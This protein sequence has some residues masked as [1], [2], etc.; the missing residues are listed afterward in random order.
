[1]LR[2]GHYLARR[3]FISLSLP[4][5]AADYEGFAA[6]FDS[7]LGEHRMLLSRELR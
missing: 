6:A 1:M 3:G 4:L 5:A 7:F 2:S